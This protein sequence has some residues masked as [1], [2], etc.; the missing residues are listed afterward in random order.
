MPTP[1]PLPGPCPACIALSRGISSP[2]FTTFVP[3]PK[4]HLY[5]GS[6]PQPSSFTQRQ[7]VHSIHP[8]RRA[9]ARRPH[10][11]YRKSLGLHVYPSR[12]SQ[13]LLTT[14]WTCV[15]LFPWHRGGSAVNLCRGGD[16]C[17]WVQLWFR[18]RQ[19]S[20][21]SPTAQ[22]QRIC[23]FAHTCANR[24]SLFH[25]RLC[26]TKLLVIWFVPSRRPNL[27]LA[28]VD[29]GPLRAGSARSITR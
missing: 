2:R 17:A 26:P 25:A 29:N 9:S 7:A 8:L 4:A 28:T 5:H 13:T 22:A 20:A 19:S 10:V 16:E 24:Y 21:A 12:T 6:V 18:L 23:L 15:R 14:L 3:R 27:K 11:L 1:T